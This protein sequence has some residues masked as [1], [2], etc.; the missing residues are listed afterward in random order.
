MAHVCNP[1][2]LP[3]MRK[4]E[5]GESSRSSQA[6]EPGHRSKVE[7]RETYLRKRAAREDT[8]TVA[9]N[10]PSPTKGFK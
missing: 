9:S 1:S 4:A 5:I 8:S 2:S 10:A 7:P 3:E 6:S